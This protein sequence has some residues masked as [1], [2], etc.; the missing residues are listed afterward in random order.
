MI[1]SIS[2]LMGPLVAGSV[3]LL[4]CAGSSSSGKGAENARPSSQC[5]DLHSACSADNDCCS[6]WCVNGECRQK[7]P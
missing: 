6:L 7:Q 4:A 5:L 1:K 2:R 3:G